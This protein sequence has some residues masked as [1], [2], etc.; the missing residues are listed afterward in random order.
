MLK[1]F[2]IRF[3]QD[4]PADALGTT[5]RQQNGI[6]MLCERVPRG[7]ISPLLALELA[8]VERH[9]IHNSIVSPISGKLM[10]VPYRLDTPA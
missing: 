2:G 3:H 10:S 5:K 7:I 1:R 6:R 4:L 8:S 9:W